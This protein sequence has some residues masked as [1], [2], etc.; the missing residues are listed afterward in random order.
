MIWLVVV[1]TG[2]ATIALKGAGPLV[3]GGRPLPAPLARVVSLVGPSLLAA[4]VAIGTFA[5]GQTLVVDERV[6]GVGAAALALA[7][8]APILLAVVLAAAVTGVA[9]AILG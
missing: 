9:R 4:L 8:R 7:L 5:S 1:T 2:V 6:L 3:L